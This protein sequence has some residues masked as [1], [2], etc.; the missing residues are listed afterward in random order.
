MIEIKAKASNSSATN[1]GF[2]IS[3]GTLNAVRTSDNI[4]TDGNNHILTELSGTGIWAYNATTNNATL[5]TIIGGMNIL[6]ISIYSTTME[7]C[8]EYEILAPATSKTVSELKPDTGYS[9]QVKAINDYGK[10]A[11]SKC[12]IFTVSTIS[13]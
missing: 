2:S 1:R 8:T 7:V 13:I 5:T 11:Y 9:Y 6:S 3:G 10:S 12:V 4:I